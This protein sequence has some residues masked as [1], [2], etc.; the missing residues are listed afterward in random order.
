M[1]Y[2]SYFANW[3]NFPSG[4]TTISIARYPP[5]NFVGIRGEV[6]APSNALLRDWKTGVIG[7]D[8]FEARYRDEVKDSIKYCLHLKNCILCCYEKK[9]DFCHRHILAEMLREQGLEVEEL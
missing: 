1:I 3:R 8:E 2:T 5:K 6:L 7:E 9:G 4:Y